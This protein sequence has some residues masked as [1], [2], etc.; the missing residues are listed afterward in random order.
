VTAALVMVA[1][2]PAHA[3]T[4]EDRDLARGTLNLK[5][6]VATKHDATAPLHL[7]LITYHDW[8]ASLLV[9]ED[10]IRFLLNTDREGRYD[11]IGVVGYRD[12][13]L[14]IR[15]STRQGRFI[16]TVRVT[17]PTPDSI[18]ATIPHGVPNP[19]GNVWLA[20]DERYVGPVDG[21]ASG[22]HDRIPNTGWLKVTPGG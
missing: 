9:G 21:C 19:D 15:I 20:A 14:V 5:R 8:S 18:R 16:R 6:L 4:I 7:W 13:R 10:R 12:G 2:V 11:F 22:C 1:A 17:H 3:A